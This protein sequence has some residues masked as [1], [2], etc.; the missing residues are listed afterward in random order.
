[1]SL[2]IRNVFY[3]FFVKFPCGYFKIPFIN[4]TI[5]TLGG[6]VVWRIL[7]ERALITPMGNLSTSLMKCLE[8]LR[9]ANKASSFIMSLRT[10]GLFRLT[11]SVYI[12]ILYVKSI[13]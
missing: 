3:F 8:L 7:S 11:F 4:V 13:S 6:E 1:M 12:K 2:K 10:G 5:M 9:E